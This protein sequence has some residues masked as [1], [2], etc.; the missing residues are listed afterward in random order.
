MWLYS[1]FTR[2]HGFVDNLGEFLAARRMGLVVEQTGGGFKLK[3]LDYIFNRVPIAPIRGSI[4]GLPMTAGLHYLS[5]ESMRELVQGVVAVIDDIERLNFMQQAAYEKCDSGF[6][7]GRPR[8]H[9]LQCHLPSC[10]AAKAYYHEELGCPGSEVVII[11]QPT[12]V[13]EQWF[14]TERRTQ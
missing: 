5:F 14:E 9:S 3:T 2:F 1:I 11:L 12:A 6:D 10:E 13:S 8:R 7:C 4:A